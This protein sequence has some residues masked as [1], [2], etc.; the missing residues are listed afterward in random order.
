MTGQLPAGASPAD[1]DLALVADGLL[2]VQEACAFSRLSRSE[3]YAR[4]GDGR[5]KFLK[6]GKRRLV[7]RRSLLE[8]LAGHLPAAR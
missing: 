6:V 2:S 5:I 7:V 4:M 1:E 8:F 3:V